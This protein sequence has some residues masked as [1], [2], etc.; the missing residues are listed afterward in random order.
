MQMD[1]ESA[2]AAL[3]KLEVLVGEWRMQA[4]LADAPAGRTAFEW[5]TGGQFLVQRWEVPHPQAPD[6]IAIIG[7][8]PDGGGYTQHYFDSRG[9]ARVYAMGLGDGVW[10]LLRERPDFSALDF[11][12]RFT[13][14]FSLGGEEITGRWETSRGGSAWE[15][16]FDLIYTRQ[17]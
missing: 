16:D 15:P 7:L 17:G 2:R 3:S 5:L 6:G 1:T 11:S 12:Q 13:G 14:K 10:T 9:V 8:A 4:S